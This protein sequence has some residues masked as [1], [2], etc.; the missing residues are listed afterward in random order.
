MS[1]QKIKND[2]LRNGLMLYFS[3]KRTEIFKPVASGSLDWSSSWNNKWKNI[4]KR[5]NLLDRKFSKKF[6]YISVEEK[7]NLHNEDVFKIN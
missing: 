3:Q 1:L 2:L 4:Q 6:N 5:G 7:Y